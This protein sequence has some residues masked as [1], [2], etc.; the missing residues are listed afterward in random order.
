MSRCTLQLAWGGVDILVRKPLIPRERE[1]EFPNYVVLSCCCGLPFGVTCCYTSY[2]H[3]RFLSPKLYHI[4]PVCILL[5]YVM[6]VKNDTLN[7]V[8]QQCVTPN[9]SPREPDKAMFLCSHPFMASIPCSQHPRV[10]NYCENQVAWNPFFLCA[11][12]T[13]LSMCRFTFTCKWRSSVWNDDR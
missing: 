3:H 10:S 2:R 9:D 6:W 11:H 1:R 4:I 13:Q 12:Y 8:W 5:A 7:K